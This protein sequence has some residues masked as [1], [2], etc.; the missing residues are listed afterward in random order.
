MNYKINGG[1]LLPNIEFTQNLLIVGKKEYEYQDISNIQILNDPTFVTNG[2]ITLIING[3][4]KKISFTKKSEETVKKAVKE[5]Q[6]LIESRKK[7]NAIEL[8]TAEALY[9]YCIY[10]GLGEGMTKKWGYKHFQ[11]IVDNLMDKEE[12]LL[13]F[14]G[15]HNYKST[16]KHDGNFAYALTNKRII[17]AQQRVMGKALQTISLKNVND[18]TLNQGPM[19]ANIIIDTIKEQF[20]VCVNK[21][22]GKNIYDK[23]HKVLDSVNI[24]SNE[25]IAAQ[26]NTN[27]SPINQIKEFKELLDIGAITEDEFNQK[28][29]ELL[30][31]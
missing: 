25:E 14:I 18:I 7:E 21:N 23:I 10:H 20:S 15:L 2:I 19:I 17:M 13:A 1:K 22:N 30:N 5:L 27:P 26:R 8:K 12:V 28:K 16:T 9:E 11:L 3:K 4:T 6:E 24:S 31:L 29:K